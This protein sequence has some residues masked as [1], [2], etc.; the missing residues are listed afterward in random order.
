MLP[1][2]Q[3]FEFIDKLPIQKLPVLKGDPASIA[4]PNG[5][6]IK[7]VKLARNIDPVKLNEAIDWSFN[8][9]TPE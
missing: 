4:W 2:D 3:T 5:D 9:A 8:R 7:K 1:P 6:L